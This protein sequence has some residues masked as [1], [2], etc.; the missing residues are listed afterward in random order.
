ML[1]GGAGLSLS[2]FGGMRIVLQCFWI[3]SAEV[4]SLFMGGRDLA[5]D[6]MQQSRWFSKVWK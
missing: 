6:F 3:R 4:K 1:M 5:R 2:L